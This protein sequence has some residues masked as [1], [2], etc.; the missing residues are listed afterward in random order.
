[1]KIALLL[2]GKDLRILTRSR[3]LIAS[4]ICYPLI[5]A[6]LIGTLLVHQS[7][8]TIALVNEGSSH[9]KIT[10]GKQSFSLTSYVK[11]AEK[12]GVTV[13]RMSR[14]DADRA[15]RKGNVSGVLVVPR[16]TTSKLQSLLSSAPVV[17]HVGDSA[18]GSVVAQRMQGV[19]YEINLHISKA[20]IAANSSYLET[21]V[22]GGDVDVLGQQ[23]TL[24]GLTPVEQDLR[25]ARD[26]LN[27]LDASPT[28]IKRL[29][30]AIS[31]A[32]AAGSA[33]DLADDA[34]NAASTPVR[35][36]VHRT[37]GI[38]PLLT[39][40]ALSFALSTMLAFLCVLL[41]ASMLAAEREDAVL[42]RLMQAVAN[43]WQI[44]ISKII[45][46]TGLCL[47][48]SSGLL[49]L[50]GLL[51]PQAWRRLPALL[52]CVALASITCSSLGALL[53]VIAKDARTA[54]LTAVLLLLPLI[55]LSLVDTFW[56]IDV[57]KGIF[58]ISPTWQLLR[59]VL[60]E[61][62]PWR[63]AARFAIHLSALTLIMLAIAGRY[64]RRLT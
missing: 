23:I 19:V 35:L 3:M 30:R 9:Q 22:S 20:L 32:G 58:P 59:T 49:I 10:I 43:P 28:L 21:L 26:E 31:F 37:K 60:F 52:I 55:P 42:G 2:C 18:L 39:A 29:D 13:R 64:L 34:M 4:L 54:T 25:A 11:Q 38:S 46:G 44:L 62:D 33:I 41:T 63:A 15:L 7:P 5:V 27:A 1:M 17:L 53:A 47:L 24:Y 16:D 50:F 48:F 6:A 14:P 8:P 56:V 40:Q 12:E 51:E 45:V 61:L 57:A 36:K